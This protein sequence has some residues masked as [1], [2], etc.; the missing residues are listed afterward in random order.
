M[1]SAA[2]MMFR[3]FCRS[4]SASIHCEL[5]ERSCGAGAPAIVCGIVVALAVGSGVDGGRGVSALAT[6]ADG[7]GTGGGSWGLPPKSSTKR[8]ICSASTFRS[9]RIGAGAREGVACGRTGC[10]G[11]AAGRA[12]GGATGRGC[13]RGRGGETRGLGGTNGG[14]SAS[15]ESSAVDCC[16]LLQP[17]AMATTTKMINQISG[18]IS[19]SFT[20]LTGGTRFSNILARD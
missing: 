8:R 13:S 20:L 16:S 3:M 5:L 14:S 15:D 9:P 6:G 18:S 2:M 19:A 17:L 1:I 4:R 12:V 11:R 7:T 10:C